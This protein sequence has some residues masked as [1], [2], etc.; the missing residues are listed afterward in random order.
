MLLFFVINSFSFCLFGYFL[1]LVF[2]SGPAFVFWSCL[3][4]QAFLFFVTHRRIRRD[5]GVA[6]PRLLLWHT[7]PS[8]NLSSSTPIYAHVTSIKTSFI[9][10][11]LLYFVI[12]SFL[13]LLMSPPISML[14]PPLVWLHRLTT[15]YPFLTPPSCDFFCVNYDV[16]PCL[17]QQ[18]AL[19][20]SWPRATSPPLLSGEALASQTASGVTHRP[21]P[22]PLGEKRLPTSTCRG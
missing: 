19:P 11:I 14:P 9:K 3:L 4:A 6:S 22:G 17:H 18:A 7:G 5:S 21:P 2:R 10:K 1:A 20:D 16:S 8:G 12:F 13:L 15:F